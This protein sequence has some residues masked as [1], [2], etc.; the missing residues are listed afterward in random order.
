M[1]FFPILSGSAQKSTIPESYYTTFRHI[2]PRYLGSRTTAN[3]VNTIDGLGGQD[4]LTRDD[5][6]EYGFG[7]LPVIDYQ[8][9]YFAYCDQVIDPYPVVNNV[10]QFNLKYLI[11]D[12]GDALQPNL[13]PYTAFDV[14]GTWTEG[15]GAR[16]GIAQISGSS[17]Y[18]QLNGLN[19]VKYVAKEPVAVL[20]SQT[21]AN[22]YAGSDVNGSIPL[23]G[24]PG[25]VSTYTAS[26]LSYNMSANGRNFETNNQNDKNIPITNALTQSS[27]A[28]LFTFNTAS[29][30][31]EVNS[32]TINQA[33]S[34]IVSSESPAPNEGNSRWNS[35]LRRCG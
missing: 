18:D 10:T 24:Q 30:Y 3:D 20:W 4:L 7:T 25:V 15:E 28:G 35:N 2:N 29:R 13:S 11:N 22:T 14:E 23:A 9:A 32:S 12:S 16:V 26:F 34:S 1:N 6:S 27:T 19:P 5:G 8:T 17:Q 33:S 21:G 31:G